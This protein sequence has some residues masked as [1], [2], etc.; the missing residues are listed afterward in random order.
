MLNVKCISVQLLI[1]IVN[2][3][4]ACDNEILIFTHSFIW[5]CSALT[6]SFFI[7]IIITFIMQWILYTQFLCFSKE[8]Q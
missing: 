7:F 5:T 2:T 6:C 1:G 8:L 3:A 4:G